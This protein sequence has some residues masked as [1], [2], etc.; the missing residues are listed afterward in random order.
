MIT[1][2]PSRIF[3]RKRNATDCSLNNPRWAFFITTTN[4]RITDCNERFVSILRSSREQLLNLDMNTLKDQRVLPALKEALAG[5]PG[6]YEGPYSATTSPAAILISMQTAP[7]LS[8]EGRIR[9]G[10]GIVEEISERKKAEEEL[11]AEKERL[12]VT[13][14]SIGDGVIT[15]DMEGRVVLLNQVAESQTG[16]SQEEAFGRFVAG[17]FLHCR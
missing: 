9:G 2:R 5:G 3:R 11:A 14:R 4:L 7:L 10:M 1:G 13:L 12:A 8:R 16:W 17:G 6:F 15:T